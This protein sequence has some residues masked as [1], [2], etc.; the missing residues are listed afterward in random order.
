MYLKRIIG[1]GEAGTCKSTLINKIVGTVC[2]T[3]GHDAIIV[4]T[5][6]GAAAA[7]TINGNTIHSKLRISYNLSTF[8]DLT[9]ESLQKFQMYNKN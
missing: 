6:T 8:K 4:T 7:V 2:E 3:L 9:A 1:Q 5:P